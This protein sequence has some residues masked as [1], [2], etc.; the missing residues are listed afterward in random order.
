MCRNHAI[1]GQCFVVVA[2]NPVTEEMIAVMDEA[3][4]PAA[5][6]HGRRR[7]VGHHPPPDDV[8]RRHT[9]LRGVDW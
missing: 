2:E 1:T 9:G 7:L 5:V 8:R 3:L 6:P 4:G